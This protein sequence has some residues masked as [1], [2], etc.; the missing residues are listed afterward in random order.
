MERFKHLYIIGNGFDIFHGLPSSYR[1]FSKWLGGDEDNQIE[2]HDLTLFNTLT[3]LYLTN[4]RLLWNDLEAWLPNVNDI[5]IM[6]DSNYFS[7]LLDID[8]ELGVPGF[9]LD[10]I[11]KS[12]NANKLPVL[13]RQSPYIDEIGLSWSQIYEWLQSNFD[14]WVKELNEKPI[15][16]ELNFD[17]KDAHFIN[18]NYTNTLE[19]IYNVPANQITYI[20][21]CAHLDEPLIFGHGKTLKAIQ[22]SYSDFSS[23]DARQDFLKGLISLRKP[24]EKIIS[25]HSQLWPLISCVED[26]HIWGHGLGSIDLPYFLKIS[27]NA[28]LK[29]TTEISWFVREED[30]TDDQLAI[31][32]HIEIAAKLDK[33]KSLG[34]SN[35]SAKHLRSYQLDKRIP[36]LSSYYD[37]P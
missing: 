20:H 19:R 28:N 9:V 10:A 5:A 17:I 12:C 15:K 3:R 29:S 11:I 22:S 23:S 30:K 34:F 31:D 16:R 4:E 6:S 26:I 14:S 2:P 24:I 37:I 18:F 1:D 7:S 8:T 35:I 36:G 32:A 27:S 33:L 21:G 13:K 25:Q